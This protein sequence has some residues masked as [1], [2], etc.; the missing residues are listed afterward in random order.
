MRTIRRTKSALPAMALEEELMCRSI[1]RDL[2]QQ[3]ATSVDVPALV[4]ARFGSGPRASVITEY[5]TRCL[6]VAERYGL[7]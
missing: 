2:A 4:A 3:G 5:I 1:A 6:E 7:R